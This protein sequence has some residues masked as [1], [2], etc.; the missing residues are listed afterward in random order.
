MNQTYT[1]QTN[2]KSSHIKSPF[3]RKLH[4]ERPSLSAPGEHQVG[5]CARTR[6]PRNAGLLCIA[7]GWVFAFA[8]ITVSSGTP[9]PEE[10]MAP[11]GLLAC[12]VAWIMFGVGW[13]FRDE[14]SE[15]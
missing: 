9:N 1:T 5:R 11:I 14:G 12:S 6:P 7:I 8:G 15:K 4:A 3:A 13:T 10:I 2:R